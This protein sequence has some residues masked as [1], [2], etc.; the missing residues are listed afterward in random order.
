[1]DRTEALYIGDSEVDIQT[2]ANAGMDVCMVGWGFR[3]EDY[4]KA[5]GAKF[6]VHTPEEIWDYV[7]R[8]KEGE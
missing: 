8:E 2:S 5:Q 4:L 1:M 6:V 7:S 3:D